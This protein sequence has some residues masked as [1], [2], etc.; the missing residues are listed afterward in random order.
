LEADDFEPDDLAPA[1][2]EPVD[3]AP[4]DFDAEEREPALAPEDFVPEDLA[5]D[6]FADAFVPDDLAPELLLLLARAGLPARLVLAIFSSSLSLIDVAIC[7]DAPLSLLFGVSP[8]LAD[9][10]A[11]A[12]FCWAF[13]LAGMRLSLWAGTGSA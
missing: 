10:A 3:F 12:A 9:N 13:D 8:R 11:P 5:P 1:D 2:F 6:D 7:L 4:A